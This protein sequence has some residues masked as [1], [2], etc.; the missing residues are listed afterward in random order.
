MFP[1]MKK[2]IDHLTFNMEEK[3]VNVGHIDS[4]KEL[5]KW[6]GTK[7]LLLAKTLFN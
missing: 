6:M 7:N 3:C 1:I 4:N 5:V 2:T